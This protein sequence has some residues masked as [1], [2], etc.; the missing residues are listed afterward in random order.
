[1][2]ALSGTSKIA[3]PSYS[4]KPY[5][6]PRREPPTCSAYARAASRRSSRFWISFYHV[7]GV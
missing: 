2:D 6:N 5:Q 4:P 7:S 1:M 3:Y